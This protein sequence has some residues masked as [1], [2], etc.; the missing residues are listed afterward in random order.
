MS[1]NEKLIIY[2]KYVKFDIALSENIVW[3]FTLAFGEKF[4]AQPDDGIGKNIPKSVDGG[5]FTQ[6]L[7]HV[8]VSVCI[9]QEAEF[10]DFF[11]SFCEEHKLPVR[12]ED[13]TDSR[14]E[15]VSPL[16]LKK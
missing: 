13:L 11:R 10:Y 9:S 4:S 3:P 2:G 12:E 16:F 8:L 5:Y 15:R 6:G 1:E 7:Y 14:S